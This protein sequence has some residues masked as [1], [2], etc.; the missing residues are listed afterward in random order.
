MKRI[1]LWRLP[2]LLICLAISL[3]A[4]AE[5][6]I[7]DGEGK[8]A[9]PPPNSKARL[10]AIN[11]D[12]DFGALRAGRTQPITHTFEFKNTGEED[13]IISKVKPSCGCTAAIPS[14]TRVA[15]G[16]TASITA[17]MNPKGKFGHQSVTVR[18]STNDATN[19]SQVFKITG[20]ILADWRVI[21]LRL[22]FG[23]VGKGGTVTKE[24][25]VSSQYMKGDAIHH[26]KDLKTDS[27]DVTAATAENSAPQ[28]PEAGH[29][30]IEVRRAVKVTIV[31]GNKEGE[32]SQA[33]HISTDD[34]ASPT[35]NV[36]V[37]WVVEGDLSIS[38]SKVFVSDVKDHKVP[39]DL[40]IASRS[41]IPFEVTSIELQGSKGND[42]LE[43][44]AKPESTPVHKVYSISTKIQTDQPTETRSGKIVFK[45][46][47]P[48]Q[49]MVTVP[50]TAI[51][52]K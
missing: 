3:R 29:D 10:E 52:R 40:V 32:R 36:T 51:V 42:D 2:V 26:I 24:V 1:G 48:A 12:Y 39:R 25:M 35:Q 13:L 34:P 41:N 27:S 9:P 19:P 28:E 14:A 7:H 21:P 20:M 37:R 38:P 46:D 44:V 18:A 43:V 22:D 47:S 6:G 11:P 33:L 5:A 17:S 49:P 31:A 4:W 30:Y 50:Y 16:N 23:P 45:T 15:P 8:E